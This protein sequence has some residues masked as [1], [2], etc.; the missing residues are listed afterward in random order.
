M[1]FL[2][3]A[4]QNAIQ[5][6]TETLRNIS[7]VAKSAANN[8]RQFIDKHGEGMKPLPITNIHMDG[9]YESAYQISNITKGGVM[10]EYYNSHH[11][12]ISWMSTSGGWV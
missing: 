5:I 9:Y 2:M 8:I 12:R 7:V 1:R 11:M 6:Y 3:N 4:Y 10:T